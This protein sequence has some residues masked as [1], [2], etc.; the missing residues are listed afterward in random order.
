LCIAGTFDRDAQA[1]SSG[2]ARCA[3]QITDRDAQADS[4]GAAQELDRCAQAASRGGAR[5][6]SQVPLIVMPMPIQRHRPLCI[7]GT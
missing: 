6:A 7:A 3:S 1:D 5:Y 2:V 4:S